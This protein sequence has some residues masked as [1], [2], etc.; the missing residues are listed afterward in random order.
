MRISFAPFTAILMGYAAYILWNV[1]HPGLAIYTGFIC[2]A[3]VGTL[4]FPESKE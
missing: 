2:L 3:S 4:F 1:G